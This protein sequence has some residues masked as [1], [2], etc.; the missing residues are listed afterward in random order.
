MSDGPISSP[1]SRSPSRRRGWLAT[2]ARRRWAQV[3]L[4]FVASALVV[5]GL[6]GDR[7]LVETLRVRREHDRLASS[8]A[9][10]KRDN[11]RLAEEIRRLREDPKAIEDVARQDLGLIRPGEVVFVIKDVPKAGRTTATAR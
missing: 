11:Q 10:L 9:S 3:G 7:G 5:N 8:I 1:P 2:P 4:L 6:I